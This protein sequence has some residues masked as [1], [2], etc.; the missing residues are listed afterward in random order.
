MP[1]SRET[2]SSC[3][4]LYPAPQNSQIVVRCG[5][6]GKDRVTVLP[7]NPIDSLKRQFLQSRSLHERDRRLGIPGVELPGALA[8]KYP[9]AG[10]N[11]GWFWVFPAPG[12]STDPRS[13]VV[14]RH[15]IHPI[16]L[17]RAVRS[18]AREALIATPGTPHTFRHSF[19]THQSGADIRTLQDLSGHKDVPTPMIYTHVLN[20]PGIAVRS[21]AETL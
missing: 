2:G 12:L 7:Q 6:G 4:Y 14:R 21:P 10:S 13:G 8:R 5:R 15:H 20:K 1:Q 11:W 3:Q 9:A 19:A 17:Q 18:A 16:L